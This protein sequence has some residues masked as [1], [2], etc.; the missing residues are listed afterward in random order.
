MG[1]WGGI[2]DDRRPHR[3]CAGSRFGSAKIAMP[4]R[5][6]VRAWFANGPKLITWA[7]VD[8]YIHSRFPTDEEA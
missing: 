7:H 4:P 8:C 2:S 1:R 6:C 3:W 5:M